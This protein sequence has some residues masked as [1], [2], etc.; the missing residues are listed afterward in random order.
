MGSDPALL[1]LWCWQAAVAPIRPLAWEPQ[2][3][4]FLGDALKTNKQTKPKTKNK[5]K[6]KEKKVQLTPI[7]P[8]HILL[9]QHLPDLPPY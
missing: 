2:Y 4:F 6:K 5:N 1:W 9:A 3:V 8:S 7:S